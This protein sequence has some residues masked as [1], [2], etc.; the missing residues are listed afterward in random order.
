MEKVFYH[1]SKD[2]IMGQDLEPRR[3]RFIMDR[4]ENGEIE[5]LCVSSTVEGCLTSIPG[6]GSFL[7]ETLWRLHNCVK[8]FKID[9]DKIGYNPKFIVT[10][11]TLYRDELVWDADITKEHWL[12][13]PVTLPDEDVTIIS[14]LDYDMRAQDLYTHEFEEA[15]LNN[16]A[17]EDK[18]IT[19]L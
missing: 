10:S 11:D 12:M 3:P 7:D 17:Y 4:L 9:T 14:I 1:I 13:N 16:P 6:G 5:R 18:D 2:L 19:D 15:Y 8:L